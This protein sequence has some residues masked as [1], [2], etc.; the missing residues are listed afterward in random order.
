M[1]TFNAA[2]FPRLF[3]AL[4][5][6]PYAIQPLYAAPITNVAALSVLIL[7]SRTSPNPMALLAFQIPRRFLSNAI[8][9]LI[10]FAVRSGRFSMHIF[11]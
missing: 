1:M 8:A 2:L 10:C 7:Y 3:L 5:G 11:T 9:C 6:Q 4:K